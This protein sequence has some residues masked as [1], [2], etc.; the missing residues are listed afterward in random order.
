ML[1]DLLEHKKQ[2]LQIF[3]FNIK[4]LNKY[5]Y[6]HNYKYIDKLDNIVS[7][8]NDKYHIAIKMKLVSI[9][10]D[11]NVEKND[12]DPKFKIDDHV[13]ISKYKNTFAKVCTPNLSEQAFMF[14]KVK[15]LCQCKLYVKWTIY[16]NFF[17]SWIDKKEAV[18]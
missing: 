7:K 6:K 16:D 14:K 2:N 1:K 18:I 4:K 8:Y 17:N 12:K 5:N 13:R 3:H 15:A 11:L 9:H 10:V